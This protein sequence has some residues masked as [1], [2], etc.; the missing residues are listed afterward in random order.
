MAKEKVDLTNLKKEIES[1]KK[2]SG[3]V[4]GT[5][6]TPKDEFLNGLLTSLNSGRK[7]D[8][9]ELIKL[10]ENKNKN[11][12]RRF[13]TRISISSL[14]KKIRRIEKSRTQYIEKS[15]KQDKILQAHLKKRFDE[16]NN[17][18][19]EILNR[20]MNKYV[21]RIEYTKASIDKLRPFIWGSIGESMVS[22]TLSALPDGYV[23]INDVV[24]VQR[25]MEFSAHKE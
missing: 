19:E 7:T 9:T 15:S 1:R 10:L 20:D 6:A 5:T 3:L 8:A 24:L 12:L 21:R 14:H 23:V 25:K 4:E 17:N 18:F 16:L 11:A 2:S 13:I 22:S